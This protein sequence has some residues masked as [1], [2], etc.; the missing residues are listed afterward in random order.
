V[1]TDPAGNPSLPGS[2]VVDSLPPDTTGTVLNVNAVTADNVVN[3]AEGAGNVTVTGTL[4][5]VPVDAAT[6]VVTLLIN[7]VTYTATVDPLTGNWTASVAGSDLLADGDKTIDA[8]AT[9]TDAAGNSSNV[10]DTQVYTV[11]TT[12]PSN[13]TTTVT[14][15]PI[16]G[17]GVVDSTEAGANQS[18][19]GTV[20]GEYSVGDVVTVNVNGVTYNTTVQAGGSW[21]VTVAGSQLVLDAD[22][23][24]NVSIAATDAAGNVGNATADASYTVNITTPVVVVN[25]ITSDNIINAAEAGAPQTVSGSVV[26]SFTVGDAVT[27]NVNGVTY[28]TTVQTGGTWSVTVPGSGLSADADSTI[29]V[30]VNVTG[31]GPITTNHSYVIDVT[32][33]NPAGAV[34]TIGTVTADNVLNAAESGGNVTLT[35]T[36]TG[37]PADA[38]TTVVTLLINNVTYT[39]TV[40]PLTGNWTASVAGSDLL[41]DGDKTIDATATF[42]DTAGNSSNITDTQ[43]YTVDV[44]APNAPDINPINATDPITGTAEPGS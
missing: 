8:K 40:D 18:I 42:T 39:A 28:N 25:P 16:T 22:K 35:G 30:T 4:T 32:A 11:D 10:T 31:V 21:T 44:T 1:A 15:N 19:S 3:A 33:P 20:S 12:P 36:L 14:I 41:A 6:T 26:G 27:V 24:I 2:E 13:S 7:G 9:F 38:A 34:L 17:D 43:V 23:V 37:I 5:G 29:N